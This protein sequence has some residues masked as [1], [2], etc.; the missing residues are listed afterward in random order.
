MEELE[1]IF[2]TKEF[3]TLP[4]WSRVWIRIKVAFIQSIR[5]Y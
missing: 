3:K 5:I 2:K 1:D 4:F